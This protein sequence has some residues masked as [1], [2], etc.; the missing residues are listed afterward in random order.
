MRC[1]KFVPAWRQLYS[2]FACKRIKS[3]N[4]Y[5]Y[6]LHE[7]CLGL[8]IFSVSHESVFALAGPIIGRY[9]E[10]TSTSSKLKV[11]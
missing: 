4:R 5:Y 1:L 6:S 7:V 8:A 9:F 3:S 10:F 11:C 2:H